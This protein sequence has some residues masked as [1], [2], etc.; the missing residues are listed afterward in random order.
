MTISWGILSTALINRRVLPAIVQSSRGEL[1]GIASRDA[2]KAKEF[3][4]LWKIPK[5]YGSYDGLLADPKIDVVYIPLPN[6][7]HTPWIVR[8]LEAGKHVLCEKPMCLTMEDMD[9]AEYVSEKTGCHLMEG[10]MHLYHP[11]THLWKRIIDEGRIGQL[12]SMRS[13]FT[14]NFDRD[15]DNYRWKSQYG[16]GALWDVGVYPVSLFQFLANEI[17]VAGLSVMYEENEIDYSTT[18]LLK[19]DSG[20][21]GQFFVSFRSGYTTD[22]VIHGSLGQLH[23]SHPYSHIENCKAYLQLEDRIE[24][25]ELPKDYLYAGEVEAMHDW[26]LHEKKPI[27]SL[28]TSR[29]VLS[30]IL[31][32]KE[33][34]F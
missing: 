32:L 34:K 22:T 28:D 11:Q 26:I 2:V 18:A 7:L 12:H 20:L 17:P 30:T 14:F 9:I 27:G 1:L 25:L 10:F 29:N 4:D 33:K 15:P 3:A 13:C 24:E 23:I 19:F 16:G 8:S 31:N 21:T 6:H 5:S